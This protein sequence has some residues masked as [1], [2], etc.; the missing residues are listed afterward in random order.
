[1]DL[2]PGDLDIAVVGAARQL[3]TERCDLATVR[4][5]AAGQAADSIMDVLWVEAVQQG[6]LG[7]AVPE[8]DGGIGLS[9][10]EQVQ[11]FEELGRYVTPGPFLACAAAAT[12]LA[13]SE[14]GSRI[15]RGQPVALGI[16]TRGVDGVRVS[17]DRL[18]G[19]LPR[20]HHAAVDR[21]LLVDVNGELW[22]V[23]RAGYQ[24]RPC[25]DSTM[26]LATADLDGVQ[27]ARTGVETSVLSDQLG[28]LAA[29][30]AV[31]VADGAVALAL[32]YAKT[33][34]Q[35]GKPIGAFQAIK[36]KLAE[37]AV[38]AETA[39]ALVVMAAAEWRDL[40]RAERIAE[41][42][43]LAAE[44]AV[45]N[46]SVGILVH[47]AMGWTVECDAQLFLKRARYLQQYVTGPDELAD[48][49]V[50]Q[51]AREA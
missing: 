24:L 50:T 32:V 35:F 20:V 19:H 43:F 11:L 42:R 46:A 49:I 36:H 14:Y 29:G 34:E 18:H 44:S 12:A 38:R 13:G 5:L 1:M 3:L 51:A 26:Q 33:R 25:I 39:R 41:A 2:L 17:G 8:S 45:E 16:D 27:G 4:L 40:G 31:G 21:P 28:L 48:A 7:M 10:L 22:W 6:W 23:E 30:M 37:A 9:V 47:G 15:L